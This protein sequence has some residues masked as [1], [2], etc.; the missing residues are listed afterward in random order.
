[1]R[2]G[3]LSKAK[4]IVVKVG[5]K[6]LV[7]EKGR[8]DR[9]QVDAI[10][11]ELN[12]VKAL[13]KE[14]ILVT[15]GAIVVGLE[16]LG[17]QKRPKLLPQLQ[18]AAAIGQS[19]LMHFYQEAFN[20][21]NLLIAQVLLTAEDLK[22]RKRHINAK[23]T[24]E[25]LLS[26]GVIPIV[27]ENDTVAV[28][29]IKFGDNDQLSALVANLVKADLLILLTD[30][31]GFLK[32]GSVVHTVFEVDDSV[33]QAAGLARDWKGT[34]GMRA[35]LDAGKIMMRSGEFMVIGNG[36]VRGILS[37]ILRDEEVGTLFIPK[38]G[39]MSGRKRWIAHFSRT[40]GALTLDEGAVRAVRDRLKSVLLPGIVD[41]SGHFEEGDTVSILDHLG[42]EIARGVTNYSEKKLQQWVRMDKTSAWECG[43]PKTEVVHRDNL[44][45]L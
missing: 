37:K 38:S 41:L 9:T 7:D 12:D 16:A 36:L 3:L 43:M 35:K 2:Q 15:S 23:N 42:N 31:D 1:M 14:V 44:V 32:D 24:F 39:R 8:L 4:R 18:A 19:R 6:L 29:E 33:R 20:K 27:N 17:L 5:T 34:G 28:D 21:R 40:Q 13:D 30:Q 45:L 10:A 22:E 11:Q 26:H 25:S